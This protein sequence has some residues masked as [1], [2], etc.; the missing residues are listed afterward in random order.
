MSSFITLRFAR[1]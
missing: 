1:H